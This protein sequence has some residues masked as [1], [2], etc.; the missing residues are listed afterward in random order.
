MVSVFDELI[1]CCRSSLI[2]FLGSCPFPGNTV[3]WNV[4]KFQCSKVFEIVVKCEIVAALTLGTANVL[5]SY[6]STQVAIS[7]VD[8]DRGGEHVGR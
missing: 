4:I 6:R 2:V 3:F 5:A 1:C 7:L 8:W